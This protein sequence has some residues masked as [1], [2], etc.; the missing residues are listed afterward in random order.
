MTG[1]VATTTMVA[2][3]TADRKGR[4]IQNEAAIRMPIKSTARVV[5]V[6]SRCTGFIGDGLEEGARGLYEG[7]R[8]TCGQALAERAPSR[9]RHHLGEAVDRDE[10]TAVLVR[11]A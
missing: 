3:I 6:R 11:L 2:Q 4:T 7:A 1:Q 9:V 5:W 10:V 8:L